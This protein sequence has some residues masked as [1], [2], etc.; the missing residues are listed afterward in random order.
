MWKNIS[1][2]NKADQ[3]PEKGRREKGRGNGEIKIY[4]SLGWI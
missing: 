2:R 4:S 1:Q 3:Q